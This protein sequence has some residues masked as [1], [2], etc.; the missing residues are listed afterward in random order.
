MTK[1]L[2]LLSLVLA[3]LC[4]LA[5]GQPQPAAP[6][7][8][9]RLL[10][11]TDIE[12]EPDDTE[13]MVRLM[14]YSDVIDIE[15]LVATTS[16][17]LRGEVNP[18]SIRSVIRAYGQVRPNL[19][20]H[21]PAF[22][23]AE[24]LLAVVK[25]GLPVYG[26]QGVGETKDS[27]G[28]DWII[29]TLKSDD[30]RPLWISVWGG[31]NTLAQALFKLRA[32]ETPDELRRLVAKLRVYTI[33]DQDDTGAWMRKTFPDLFYIVSPGGYGAATW[34]GM[35]SAVPGLDNES[36]SNGWIARNIQQGHGPLG[37]KY[38]DVGYGMEGD[39]PSWLGLIP[40]GLDVPEH[41]DFGGW[42]G[43]YEL[44]IPDIAETDPTGFNGKVPIEQETR[45]IWTNSVDEYAP[46]AAFP[47][48]SAT[49]ASDKTFK[50]YRATIYRWRDEFQN[51]FAARM[52]WCTQPYAGA[53]HPP[54]PVLAHPETLTVKSGAFFSLDARA[55]S[56]PDGDSLGFYWFVYP[57]ATGTHNPPKIDSAANLGRVY[58]RAPV[59]TAPEIAHVI[60]RLTDKGNPSLT[61]YKRVIV[62][63]T[64]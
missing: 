3:T 1:T 7:S 6:E 60:L 29:R 40:N 13:S 35:N 9:Q 54:V 26:M 37:A 50:D 27:E 32:T 28:S 2:A 16:T 18:E 49:R 41:P 14:L 42:G 48:G 4:P 38:P 12:N 10:V 61:R 56:D 36:V 58:L 24:S 25:Q 30:P 11:L 52:Q 21:D 51:D 47:H 23:S 22:P 44:R 59:V 45:P 33:S 63:V 5:T 20:K 8:R 57:E 43:R 19:L 64:P 53:N 39:T 46:P 17:H 55:S 34:T 62:T 15:G 31:S